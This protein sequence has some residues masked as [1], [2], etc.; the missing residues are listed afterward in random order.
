MTL[1]RRISTDQIRVNPSHQ[2]HPWSILN[3]ECER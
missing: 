2:C 3:E 1:I